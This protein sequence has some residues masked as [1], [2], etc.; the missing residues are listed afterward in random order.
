MAGLSPEV[1]RFTVTWSEDVTTCAHLTSSPL[2]SG[3]EKLL[4]AYRAEFASPSSWA[5]AQVLSR[6][7][8]A[9]QLFVAMMVKALY[10]FFSLAY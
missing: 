2:K 1:M 8:R 6:A 9:K 3:V 4:A 7:L 5:C 10:Y